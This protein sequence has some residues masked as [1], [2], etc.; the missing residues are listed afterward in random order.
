MIV[1][2]HAFALRGNSTMPEEKNQGRKWG[3]G[4]ETLEK[5][6]LALLRNQIGA[7]ET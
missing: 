4:P 1:L 6:P 5:F 2:V 3:G 7:L